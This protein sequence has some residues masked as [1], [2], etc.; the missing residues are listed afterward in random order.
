MAKRIFIDLFK[1]FIISTIISTAIVCV[2]YSVTQK[3]NDYMHV[4]NLVSSG[5]FLLNA[6]L[7]IMSLP[8]L[9]LSLPHV[10]N[11]KIIKLLFYFS[12]ILAFI[13]TVFF[14]QLSKYDRVVY[15]ITGAI[16]AIVH[17]VFYY[18]LIK[19]TH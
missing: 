11:S 15:L 19:N 8:S 14:I 9:F 17:I 2:F 6:I 13:I 1:T 5:V 3:T 7:V 12:G 4:V 10:W 18:R 16:F